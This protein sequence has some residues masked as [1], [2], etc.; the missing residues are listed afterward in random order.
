MPRED[1]TMHDKLD[2]ILA[3]LNR[4]EQRQVSGS[5]PS[6]EVD[7]PETVKEKELGDG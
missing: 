5:A 3:C 6:V 2:E 4:I 1:K 7:K